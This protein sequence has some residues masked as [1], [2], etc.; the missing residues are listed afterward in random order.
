MT[1]KLNNSDTNHIDFKPHGGVTFRENHNSN[2]SIIGRGYGEDS[3]VQDPK[4]SVPH[5]RGERRRPN[6]NNNR[7][8][9]SF[10]V[11]NMGSGSSKEKVIFEMGTR[12][13]DVEQCSSFLFRRTTKSAIL[14]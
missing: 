1:A 2:V 10:Y 6:A 8:R 7:G 4:P 12:Q 14:I 9:G 3:H 11:F 13:N 5:K